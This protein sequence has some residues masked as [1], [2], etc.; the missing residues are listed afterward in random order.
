MDMGNRHAADEVASPAVDT[1]RGRA[2]LGPLGMALVIAL[3][4]F[5]GGCAAP[6]VSTGRGHP[7]HHH[8]PALVTIPLRV[9][10]VANEFMGQL[11]AGQFD[12]QWGEL[13]AMARAQ[14]PSESARAAM[15]QAKFQGTSKILSYTLGQVTPAPSWV[16]P[17]DPAQSISGGWQV[18]VK[19]SFFA[20]NAMLPTGVAAD[21]AQL[22][23]VVLL[24]GSD[25]PLVVGEGPASLDAPIIEPAVTTQRTAPVPILM[26]HVV[27]PFPV[28]TQWNSRYAYSL[29]YGLTVTPSQFSAQMAYLAS[30]QAHA[31]SL[32]RLTDFLL[33]GLALPTKPV[34]ITFDD[35]RESPFQNAVPILT[36]YGYT[37]TFF[38]PTGLVG[39][40]V[41]T[42]TGTNPQHYMSW[43]QLQQLTH[44]GFW[45]EDHSLYDNA[46]LW[47][48]SSAA[49]QELAG[50]TA[51]ALQQQTGQA[52]QFIAYSGVWPYPRSTEV[53]PSQTK[54]FSE[55]EALGYVGGAVDARTDSD[56]QSGAQLWQMPRVRVNPNEAGSQLAPWLG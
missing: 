22:P 1:S 51:V 44:S 38:V 32:T 56:L 45:V 15:L 24:T 42:E 20:P 25:P 37:A 9:T 35:G 30:A 17:E 4:L 27:A 43:V 50:A 12:L 53:G 48:Q 2:Q 29:E 33:Y 5:V 52:V 54:L 21:Y 3:V 13:S 19:V 11:M 40:F 14:W 26:Y 55:L 31:I 39:K 18:P 8:E 7:T 6:A 41:T 36:K 28:R 34:L 49:V 46:A 47:G 23:L 16:S 10:V